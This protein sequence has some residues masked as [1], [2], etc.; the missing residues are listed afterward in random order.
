VSSEVGAVLNLIGTGLELAGAVI[1]IVEVA[2]D[3]REAR[4]YLQR[5]VTVR[6][7]TIEMRMSLPQVTLETSPQPWTDERLDGL[8][9]AVRELS[10]SIDDAR[11]K[12]RKE[13]QQAIADLEGRLSAHIIDWNHALERLAL[14]VA[15]GGLRWRYVG[16][17]LVILGLLCNLA[18]AVA[19][20]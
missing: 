3:V 20:L 18:A 17:G 8:E 11:E 16:V 19:E 12:L 4:K 13:R 2:G 5:D 9:R 7:A 14:G 15:T 1:L 10:A 6:P